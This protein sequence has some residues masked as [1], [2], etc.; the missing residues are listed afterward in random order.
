M[1]AWPRFYLESLAPIFLAPIFLPRFSIA[2]LG[3]RI[4]P[5]DAGYAAEITGHTEKHI[6]NCVDP[7]QPSHQLSL[8]AWELMLLAGMDTSPM[9][10]PDPDT[11]LRAHETTAKL[12]CRLLLKQTHRTR[13]QHIDS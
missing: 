11:H 4:K 7:Q 6:R 2:S 12:L 5:L 10:T 9:E 13:K 3:R 8:K 1:K